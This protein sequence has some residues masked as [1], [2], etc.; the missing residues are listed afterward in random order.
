MIM[1]SAA[2]INIHKVKTLFT[3]MHKVNKELTPQNTPIASIN[4]LC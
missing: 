2:A 3:N 4:R 1:A